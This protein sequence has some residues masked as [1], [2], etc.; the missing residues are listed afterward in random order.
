[1]TDVQ[2]VCPGTRED[3]YIAE[4]ELRYI[5]I[6]GRKL[7]TKVITMLVGI[8]S[9]NHLLRTALHPLGVGKHFSFSKAI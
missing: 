6:H 1:M 5:E 9:Q 4:K 7:L 2:L 3:N 8:R